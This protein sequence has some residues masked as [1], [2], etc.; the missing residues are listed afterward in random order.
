MDGIVNHYERKR[1]SKEKKKKI[2]L[3]ERMTRRN[4]CRNM[5]EANI[6]KK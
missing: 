2:L 5:K 4:N 3:K 6:F 1:K